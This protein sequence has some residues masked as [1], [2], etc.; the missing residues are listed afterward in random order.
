MVDEFRQFVAV[1]NYEAVKLGDL[2]VTPGSRA[3]VQEAAVREETEML[4]LR[5]R[6]HECGDQQMGGR[7]LGRTLSCHNFS[8][9]VRRH[10]QGSDRLP[11]KCEQQ[12]QD[13]L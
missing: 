11:P 9:Q 12:G 6:Y 7:G 10:E 13:A 1:G 2:S 4:T 8:L 3:Q 5:I